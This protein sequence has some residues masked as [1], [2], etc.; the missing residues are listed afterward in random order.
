[1]GKEFV[2]SLIRHALTAAGSVLVAKGYVDS[3]TFEAIV[4]GLLAL[5]GLGLSY[6]DKAKRVE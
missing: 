6:Q 4:G 3:G 1:M 5:V 2:L